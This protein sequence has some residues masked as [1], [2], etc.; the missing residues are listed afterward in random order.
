MLLRWHPNF[1]CWGTRPE[2][3]GAGAVCCGCNVVGA[4]PTASRP[5]DSRGRACQS[6]RVSDSGRERLQPRSES[7]PEQGSKQET[8][9]FSIKDLPGLRQQPSGWAL[10]I[11]FLGDRCM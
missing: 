6:A 4:K 11:L 7:C 1:A 8:Q 2:R 3:E 9:G 5:S 10:E